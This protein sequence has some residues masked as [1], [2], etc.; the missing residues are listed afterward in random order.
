MNFIAE[1]L[2]QRLAELHAGVAPN[3]Y[4]VAFSGGLDSTVLLHALASQQGRH[5]VPLVAVHC[6]HGLQS[7]AGDWEVHCERF[8][9]VLGVPIVVRRLAISPGDRR[10]V[11]A[12]ARD[13]RYAAL[14][15]LVRDND[16]VLSAHHEDDQAETLMLNLLRGSGAGGVAGIGAMQRFGPARLCRPLLDIPRSDLL[17]YAAEAGLA[18]VEDPSNAD[19]RFDRNWLRLEIMPRLEARWAGAAAGLRRSASLASETRGLLN[20]LADLDLVEVGRPPGQAQTLHLPGL[21]SLSAARQ[22]NVLRRAIARCGLPPAPARRLV[23][24]V[25]TFLPASPGAQPLVGWPGAELRRYRDH[26]FLLPSPSASPPGGTLVL[27][28]DGTRLELGPGLGSIQ[29][30]P[31]AGGGISRE[32]VGDE[33]EVRFRGGGERLRPHG[34]RETHRLKKLLQDEGIVPWMRA[35][36]PL[37]YADGRLVAV[38]D[39]WVE[40]SAWSASGLAVRWQDRPRLT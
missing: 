32:C 40:H 27:P 1:R 15:D 28:A 26:V 5:G 38:G 18:W 23:E 36:I 24:A 31:D 14:R 22:R 20:E 39:L 2:L 16:T 13:A 6:N 34:R 9:A 3:R 4:V 19:T 37:L 7:S 35:S 8:A 29:L 21:R 33:L 11:E 17:R 30:H 10:G 25:E 12:A